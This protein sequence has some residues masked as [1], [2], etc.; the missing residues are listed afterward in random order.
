MLLHVWL[1]EMGNP[2]M[3]A[4]VQGNKTIPWTCELG[5]PVGLHTANR[6]DNH[7]RWT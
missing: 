3:L 2:A 7:Y 4:A 6:N 5:I 1:F